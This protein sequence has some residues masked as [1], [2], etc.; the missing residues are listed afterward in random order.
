MYSSQCSRSFT[1]L[2]EN[3]QFLRRR[4]LERVDLAA[5]R[6]H[7]GHHVLDRAVLSRGVHRLEDE[8]QRPPVVRVEALL[9]L[10]EPL[11]ALRLPLLRV[12]LFLGLE[13]GGVGGIAVLE[14]ELLV[15]L[16]PELLERS[17]LSINSRKFGGFGVPSP[18]SAFSTANSA[19]FSTAQGKWASF[20]LR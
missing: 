6:V 14:P 13:A 1:S 8:Q 19:I 12:R 4:L 18:D 7:A 16:D 15:G 20:R 17:H 3:F 10:P 11:D 2:S 9:Q 5:L